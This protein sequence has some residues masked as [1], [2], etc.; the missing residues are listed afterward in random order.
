MSR[1]VNFQEEKLFKV[2]SSNPF[3]MGVHFG[4]EKICKLF[5]ELEVV[6][7]IQ[8]KRQDQGKPSVIYLKQF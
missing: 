3:E 5:A 8:R 2:I 1:G 7:L 6:D 4:H